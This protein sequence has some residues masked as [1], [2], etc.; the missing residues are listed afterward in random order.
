MDIGSAVGRDKGVT[1]EQLRDLADYPTSPHFSELE[2]LALRLADAMSAIPAEVPLELYQE[3]RVHLD[4]AQ[5]V[6]L[7]SAIA[8]ENL[9]ARFN[10]VFD[11][12]SD[13][14]SE[15]AACAVPV[16]HPPRAA[17]T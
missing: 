17:A 3:L 2:R 5:M 11:I 13:G 12:G 10:R 8:L 1:E 7:A 6:E 16:R 4:E 9:R 14:F 15:G